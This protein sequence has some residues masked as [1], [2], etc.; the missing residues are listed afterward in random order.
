MY[1]MFEDGCQ[2]EWK[3]CQNVTNIYAYI[4]NIFN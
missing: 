1:I 4:I 3:Q 2:S